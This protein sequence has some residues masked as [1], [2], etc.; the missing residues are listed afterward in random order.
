MSENKL[1]D[2]EEDSMADKEL[3]RKRTNND[4]FVDTDSDHDGSENEDRD[5]DNLADEEKLKLKEAYITTT[6][7][8]KVEHEEAYKVLMDLSKSVHMKAILDEDTREQEGA[9]N[10]YFIVSCAIILFSFIFPFSFID[11]LVHCNKMLL[12]TEA[13]YEIIGFVPRFLF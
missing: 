10:L 5:N 4:V 1:I 7:L 9:P 2:E 6:C 11:I 3:K 12:L 13:C 8:P